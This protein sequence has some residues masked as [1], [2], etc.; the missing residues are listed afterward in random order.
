MGVVGQRHVTAAL[1]PGK[2]PV[3]IVQ[4]TGWAAGPVWTGAEN[5]DLPGI[6]SPD[7]LKFTILNIGKIVLFIEVLIQK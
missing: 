5:L 7:V 6:R 1:S 2:K 4:E 3:P